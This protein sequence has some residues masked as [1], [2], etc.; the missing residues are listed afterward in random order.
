MKADPPSMCEEVPNP[1]GQ[2]P[3]AMV[4]T[5]L[6]NTV[7]GLVTLVTFGFVL[8]DLPSLIDSAQPAPLIAKQAVGS[9]AGAFALMI[10]LMVLAVI[11][12]I[13]CTTAASRVT[14]AFSR[15][16][17]IPGYALWRRVHRGMELPFNAMMLSMMVQ[18]VLGAIYFGSATAFNSFSAAGIICLTISNAAPIG[19]SLVRGRRDVKGGVFYLGVWGTVSN[20]VS[21]GRWLLFVP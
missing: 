10:P 18:L 14:W 16:G 12:G 17:G 15:D 1:R 8:P 13:G 3:K 6:L 2:V 4:G 7:A 9:P 21:L 5:I 11:C 19:V 20:Y